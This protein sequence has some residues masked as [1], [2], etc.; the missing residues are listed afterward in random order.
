MSHPRP[1]AAVVLAAGEGTR[2]RSSVPKMLHEIGGR[3]LVGHAL[4]AAQGIAPERIAVVVRHGRDAVAAHVTQLDPSVLVVDQDEIPG[5]GRA[6]QCAL[7]D[8]DAAAQ[9]Q[10]ARSGSPAQDGKVTGA[11]VV[12]AGDVPLLD[13]ATLDQLLEAHHADGNAVTVLTTHVPDP[14]G[15]GRIL[16]EEGTGDVLGIV[17]EADADAD[18][19]ALDEIN[20]AVYVFDAT[21][22]RDAL[23]TLDGDDARRNAQGEVY[24]TDVLA[25]ARDAGGLVRAV[26][27]EDTPSVEGVNDRTQLAALGAELNRRILDGWMREGV[28]VVDP[29]TTWV[30]VDVELSRDVT[31]LP[32]VQLRGT[33]RVAE[34]ATIGPDTTLLDVEVGEG[35]TVVRTHGS[36]AR[37]GA[38]A[39][40]G[41]FAYLRPGTHLGEHGK[42]GTFVETKNAEIADG[43]K[44]PH[45]TYVGDAT[46]GAGS[47]IGAGVVFANY[48]GVAKHRTDVGEHSFVGSDSVLVAPIRL[49]DGTYVAAGS[50]I[51][52][53]VGP[54][55]LAVA[56]GIQ[57]NVAGWVQRRRAGSR[58]AEAAQ[59]ALETEDRSDLSP[60]ARAELA[61]LAKEKESGA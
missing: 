24:L 56:R 35:A 21:A 13:A 32:G 19:R 31:L 42:I 36:E 45:L 47:N 59:A 40:V 27:T 57:R 10:L 60:Q 16:R 14:T 33:T 41:P 8:L 44:V 15:Y 6:V 1:A 4:T 49:A 53:D 30:D 2:M 7:A 23:R 18:Q 52:R 55:E 28:T 12:L 26:A 17:E 38:G 22:L 9:A 37:I 50:T 34:G 58:S 48:D 39:K 43:A 20:T 29:A 25:L 61:R 5:T 46:I 54:G 11:V 3:S 51:T